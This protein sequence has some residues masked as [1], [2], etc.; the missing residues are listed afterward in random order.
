M[1]RI[2]S[3]ILLLASSAGAE[4]NTG[5][6]RGDA[7]QT[8]VAGT[9]L[10]SKFQAI[11]NS[12]GTSQ[13]VTAGIQNQLDQTIV[14]L[15]T[16]TTAL[17]AQITANLNE[18]HVQSAT[19]DADES[20]YRSGQASFNSGV[21]TTATNQ[22]AQIT[23]NLNEFHVQSAT[24]DADEASYR[25]AQTT[26]N[27][28]QTTAISTGASATVQLRTD[29]NVQSTT[30]AAEEAAYR[31]GV[32]AAQR[33][34][35]GTW[36]AAQTFTSMTVN[37]I[38]FTDGTCAFT[39]RAVGASSATANSTDFNLAISTQFV[40]VATVTVTMVGGRFTLIDGEI[41]IN[42]QGGGTKDYTVRISRGG[43]PITESNQ[44]PIVETSPAGES[45][46]VHVRYTLDSSTAG[47]NQFTLEISPSSTSGTQITKFQRL[48]IVER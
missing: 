46:T 24:K 32:Q 25:S 38:C 3:A 44:E 35:T 9:S 43:V 30:E 27:N 41:V 18:F 26:L 36:T 17:Q 33:A 22:Q 40:Q 13:N 5:S 39:N 19:K 8:T 45:H 31:A 11:D 1:K 28:A 37:G 15:S 34:S 6:L 16:N 10:S 47:S 14:S 4:V 23:A 48:V 21:S 20:S 42:N 29:F 2:I 7:S 12:T